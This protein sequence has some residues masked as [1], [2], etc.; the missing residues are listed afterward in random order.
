MTRRTIVII[1]ASDGIGAAAARRL[2]R[3]GENVV[4]VGRSQSETAAVAAEASLPSPAA[5]P[6]TPTWPASCG[7][8]RWRKSLNRGEVAI[9]VGAFGEYE[10]R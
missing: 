7:I 9:V 3:S 5:R 6:T 4:V 10:S 8:A 2:R 1:G